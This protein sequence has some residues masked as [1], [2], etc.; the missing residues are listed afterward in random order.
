VSKVAAEAQSTCNLPELQIDL[1]A[2]LPNH[3]ID[4]RLNVVALASSI[5]KR[6]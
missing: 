1:L 3:A 4:H 5:K 6:A 2:V